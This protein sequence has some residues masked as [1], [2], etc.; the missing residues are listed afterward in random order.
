MTL[1]VSSLGGEDVMFRLSVNLVRVVTDLADL[2][3]LTSGDVDGSVEAILGLLE[4]YD[5]HDQC[6][7]ELV[8][9]GVGE[10]SEKDVNLEEIAHDIRCDCFT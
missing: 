7:M 6:Q 9:F 3:P 10:I 1:N 8:H 5:A 2:S 4:S